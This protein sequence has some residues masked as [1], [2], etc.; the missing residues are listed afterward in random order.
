V[1]R[2]EEAGAVVISRGAGGGDDE[3]M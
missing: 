3:L 2:L 1:R